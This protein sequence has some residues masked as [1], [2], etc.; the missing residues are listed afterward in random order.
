[1]A[2]RERSNSISCAHGK[3]R[4]FSVESSI[5]KSIAADERDT[6]VVDGDPVNDLHN[7]DVR[8]WCEGLDTHLF[9]P[10]GC[11]AVVILRIF[12]IQSL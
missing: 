4:V 8:G 2:T 9:G 5:T 1:M 11:E 10:G 6:E 7:I 12:R 3:S